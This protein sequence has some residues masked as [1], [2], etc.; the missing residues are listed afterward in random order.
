MQVCRC[1]PAEPHPVLIPVLGASQVTITEMPLA[2][3]MVGDAMIGVVER[4][5][6]TSVNRSVLKFRSN[7]GGVRDSSARNMAV[8]VDCD[9]NCTVLPGSLIDPIA[10]PRTR[11]TAPQGT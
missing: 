2:A 8:A 11:C 4:D 10:G 6:A 9:S 1:S 5:Y 7:T 3:A